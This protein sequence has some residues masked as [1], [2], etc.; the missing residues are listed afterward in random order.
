MYIRYI[1]IYSFYFIFFYR[2]NPFLANSNGHTYRSFTRIR[3]M[4]T[5]DMR[6]WYHWQP[7]IR[8][9]LA[10]HIELVKIVSR[11]MTMTLWFVQLPKKRMLK[12]FYISNIIF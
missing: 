8:Y 11:M 7:I 2:S 3:N 10:H 1:Q 6:C 12:V 9:A 4:G 5:T